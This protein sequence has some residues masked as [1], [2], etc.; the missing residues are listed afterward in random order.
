MTVR[1]P[2]KRC[3]RCGVSKPHT[4][5]HRDPTKRDGR[6]WE[7]AVCKRGQIREMQSGVNKA[8]YAR[9]RSKAKARVTRAKRYNQRWPVAGAVWSLSRAAYARLMAL[10]CTVCDNPIEPTGVGLD[11][12]DNDFGYLP[13]NVQPMCHRCNSFK[14]RRTMLQWVVFLARLPGFDPK[15]YAQRVRV[16][17]DAA[18]LHPGDDE[19]EP[20]VCS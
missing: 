20:L 12:I 6:C 7:C 10:P 14:H 16:A 11:R 18:A 3:G 2:Q 8:R 19:V 13:G 5:F 1:N 9:A 17:A 4:D 15:A